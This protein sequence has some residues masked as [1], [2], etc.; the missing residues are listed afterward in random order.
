M[1]DD[2]RFWEL[3]PA[4]YQ[5][6]VNAWDTKEYRSFLKAGIVAAT[7]ANVHRD[8][9]QRSQPFSPED[10]A[11]S[12]GDRIMTVEESEAALTR[13]TLTLGGTIKEKVNGGSLNG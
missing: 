11:P 5:S 13:L 9:K 12:R 2:S 4:E 10:F 1:K 8:P 6:L 3:T 7:V